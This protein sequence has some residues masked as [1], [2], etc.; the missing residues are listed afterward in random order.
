MVRRQ[1]IKYKT[2][3]SI[4]LIQNLHCVT[5]VAFRVVDIYLRKEAPDH[6]GKRH[7]GKLAALQAVHE[8]FRAEGRSQGANE[9]MKR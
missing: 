5:L 9:D 1:C 6:M 4:F 8:V 7:E 2:G 3:S